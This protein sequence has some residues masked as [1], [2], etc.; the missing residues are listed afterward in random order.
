MCGKCSGIVTTKENKHWNIYHSPF[1]RHS[2]IHRS[3]GSLSLCLCVAVLPKKG[4]NSTN[5][6]Q[7]IEVAVKRVAFWFAVREKL[8]R[9][10]NAPRTRSISFETSKRKQREDNKS[11]SMWIAWRRD[12]LRCEKTKFKFKCLKNLRKFSEISIET[13]KVSVINLASP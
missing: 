11:F 9:V 8:F 1:P 10:G 3:Q 4:Q 12:Q 5:R 6:S 7:S 13:R 2:F